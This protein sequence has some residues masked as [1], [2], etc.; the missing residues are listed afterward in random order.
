MESTEKTNCFAYINN[1]RCHA[2]DTKNCVNCKF[3][4]DREEIKNNP[5]YPFSYKSL[6]EYKEARKNKKLMFL[7]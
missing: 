6:E 4:K 1:H 5:F 3:Y 7:D 2:L